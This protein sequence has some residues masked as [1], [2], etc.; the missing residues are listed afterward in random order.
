MF[1]ILVALG[2]AGVAVCIATGNNQAA[3]VAA[4]LTAIVGFC[5][6]VKHNR[7]KRRAHS[8]R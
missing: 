8:H 6:L 2:N 4:T 3:A 5:W 1:A 7:S